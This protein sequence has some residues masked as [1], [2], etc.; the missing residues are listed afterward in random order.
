MKYIYIHLF[1]KNYNQL[2]YYKAFQLFQITDKLNSYFKK[3]IRYYRYA[4]SVG[5]NLI[6]KAPVL[7]NKITKFAMG[8]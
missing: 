1:C 8:F 5:F 7:K 4:N 2:S 3:D 6:N